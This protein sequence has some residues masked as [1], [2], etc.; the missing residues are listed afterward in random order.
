MVARSSAWTT[1]TDVHYVVGIRNRGHAHCTNNRTTIASVSTP[2]PPPWKGVSALNINGQ[3]SFAA[4][5][6][7]ASL[8]SS[9]YSAA[10]RAVQVRVNNVNLANNGPQT[11]GHLRGERSG[12]QRLGRALAAGGFLR[13]IYRALRDIQP[14]DFNYRELTTRRPALV[15]AVQRQREQLGRRHWYVADCRH[16]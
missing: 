11:W 13:N 10:S 16:Q 12:Q 9:F 5:R 7:G 2:T 4:S 6:R 14:D 3:Y 8:K 1:G 15:Q